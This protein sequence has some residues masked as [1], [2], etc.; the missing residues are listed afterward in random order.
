MKICRRCKAEY[1]YNEVK[2][3]PWANQYCC[4][5]CFLNIPKKQTKQKTKFNIGDEVIF[6][7]TSNSKLLFKTF[8]IID[9][10]F[11]YIQIK[12]IIDTKS[13]IGFNTIANEDQ[14]TKKGKYTLNL[15]FPQ[16][17]F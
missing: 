17:K 6:I 9:I 10:K 4:A 13:T 2:Q 8:S 12:Y 14:I 7:K 3:Y 11:N 15:I 16:N 5:D 1:N